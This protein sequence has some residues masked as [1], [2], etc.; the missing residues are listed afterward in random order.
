MSGCITGQGPAI[1]ATTHQF[2]DVAATQQTDN[3]ISTLLDAHL[4]SEYVP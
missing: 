1:I 3:I 2:S 4:Q